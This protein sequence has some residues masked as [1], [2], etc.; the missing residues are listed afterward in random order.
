MNA[1]H[2]LAAFLRPALPAVFWLGLALTTVV[3]LMPGSSLP[4]ALLFWDKAQ[5]GIAYSLL[6]MSGALAFPRTLTKLCLALVVHGVLLELLQSLFCRGRYGD[7]YD[8]LA[9][10]IGV[11]IG[12]MLYKLI[13]SRRL[14]GAP[15]A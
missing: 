8:I 15:K 3:G 2:K 13:A 14:L 9:D 6:A 1:M 7:V 12:L 10:S 4:Q 5:H 11:F